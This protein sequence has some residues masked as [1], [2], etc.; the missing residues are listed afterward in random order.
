MAKNFD[1]KKVVVDEFGKEYIE[2]TK[3]VTRKVKPNKILKQIEN[4]YLI[5]AKFQEEKNKLQE[6]YNE[7]TN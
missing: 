3:T 5:I 7:L 4:L 6:F 2:I 1:T